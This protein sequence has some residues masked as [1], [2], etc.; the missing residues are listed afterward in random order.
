MAQ[1]ATITVIDHTGTRVQVPRKPQRIVVASA[2]QLPAI[3]TIFFDLAPH[4]IAVPQASWVA[5]Q[6]G[7]LGQQ[8]PELLNARTDFS[9]GY[10]LDVAAIQNLKPDLVFYD[11]DTLEHQQQLQAAG[12]TAVGLSSSLW[13]YDAVQ[14]LDEAINWLAQL[15]Q[16]NA[17]VDIVRQATAKSLQ[18]VQARVQGLTAAQRQRVFFLFRYDAHELFTSGAQF[19]GQYWA[20]AVGARNVA[21]THQE[22]GWV[23]T[24]LAEIATWQPQKM[25]LTNFTKAQPEALYQNQIGTDDWTSLAAVQ[26]RQVYKMPLCSYRSFAPGV[27][28]PL[29]LLWLA[30][31]IYPDLFAELDLLAV[32]ADY[33]QRLYHV[34]LTTAQLQTMYHPTSA[35]SAF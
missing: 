35:A 26:H 9:E 4:L 33:Y 6:Q 21:E 12:L 18:H 25:L 23:A 8:Y 28:N 1:Q 7:F 32:T 29:T 15:F 17:K 19:F 16:P 31:T 11:A 5:A 10:R 13:Q 27:D 24:D 34:T 30:Q 22:N 20:Q 2:L 14:T 3:L